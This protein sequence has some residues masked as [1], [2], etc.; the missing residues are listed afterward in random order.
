MLKIRIVSGRLRL[1]IKVEE[2]SRI[3]AAPIADKLA[4]RLLV[5]LPHATFIAALAPVAGAPPPG[6]RAPPRSGSALPA[7]R[8]PRRDGGVRCD[9]DGGESHCTRQEAGG[10][11]E[12]AVVASV[13]SEAVRGDPARPQDQAPRAGRCHGL[14]RLGVKAKL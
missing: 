2:V 11:R 10:R 1:D 12:P 5:D 14:R 3:V 13:G 7:E 8:Y 6:E 9:V 4:A